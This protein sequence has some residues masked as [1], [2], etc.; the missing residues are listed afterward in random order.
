MDERKERDAG[1]GSEGRDSGKGSPAGRK[2]D[3]KFCEN[4]G[5]VI[6]KEAVV[7]PKCG[8]ALGDLKEQ[9]L[10]KQLKKKENSSEKSRLVAILLCW[11]LGVFGVHRFYV[12]KIGTGILWLLTLGCL[13]VGV[14]VDLILIATGFFKDK[15]GKALLDWTVD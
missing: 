3:K 14:L 7:C 2:P 8:V 15:D 11:F 13:W 6:D 10:N 4:C 5:A 12:G 9:L 1:R